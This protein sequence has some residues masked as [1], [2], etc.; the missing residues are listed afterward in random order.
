MK[1][2]RPCIITSEWE[3]GAGKMGTKKGPNVILN[4]Y[5]SSQAEWLSN[6]T[7]IEVS[8]DIE[9]PSNNNTPNPVEIQNS[10]GIIGRRSNLKNGPQL[11]EHQM[12]FANKVAHQLNS[13]QC[14]IL[15]TADHSNGIGGVSGLC[16]TVDAEEVGVIWI[17]AHY[18]LHSPYTTPSGNSHGMAVNA[19]I[20]DNN[21]DCQEQAITPLEADLWESIKNIKGIGNTIP[22]RNVAFIGVRDFEPAEEALVN[23]HKICSIHPDEI[24]VAGIEACINKILAHLSHCKYLYVSFDVDSM[25]PSISVATGTPVEG[26]L[27]IEQ[28]KKLVHVLTSDSRTQCL[29]ITEFNP[30][31]PQ[32]EEMLAAI[33]EILS[34][35]GLLG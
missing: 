29:E 28:A 31:L 3:Y 25:D 8:S 14:C 18:D 4:A 24:A 5:R 30:T 16:K 20:D 12:S 15:L 19:L 9:I 21:N 1:E 10:E 13:G 7:I 34:A 2:K 6:T 32:P 33:Q 22:C 23:K 35:P 11:L 26:G 27:T 17:D